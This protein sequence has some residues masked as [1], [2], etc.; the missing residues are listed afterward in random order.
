MSRMGF[1][2]RDWGMITFGQWVDLFETY[3]K[4]FN[5]E[6]NHG[7]YQINEEPKIDSLDDI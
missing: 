6:S 1:T 7:I 3:K 5:F 4:Q 2:L